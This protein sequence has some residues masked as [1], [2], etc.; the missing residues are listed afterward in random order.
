MSPSLSQCWWQLTAS[1]L[2]TACL[3]IRCCSLLGCIHFPHDLK[4]S[5]PMISNLASP[6][7]EQHLALLCVQ[8][9]LKDPAPLLL[10]QLCCQPLPSDHCHRACPAILAHCARDILVCHA[11]V[12][13]ATDCSST[14]ERAISEHQPTW[15]LVLQAHLHRRLLTERRHPAQ[16]F[17]CACGVSG[18]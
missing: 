11:G 8:C 13:T 16:H 10:W 5:K 7:S 14:C 1:A 6:R 9:H 15:Q 17:S 2:F 12:S 4:P 3:C 18:F